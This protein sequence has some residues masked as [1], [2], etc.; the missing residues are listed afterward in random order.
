VRGYLHLEVLKGRG[1]QIG[2]HNYLGLKSGG[3]DD[4]EKHRNDPVGSHV[5]GREKKEVNTSWV[6]RAGCKGRPQ[7]KLPR[8][9]KVRGRKGMEKRT[10][11]GLALI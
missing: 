6:F 11:G 10:S 5:V 7:Q 9:K 8:E 4:W 1:N 3:G 2:K